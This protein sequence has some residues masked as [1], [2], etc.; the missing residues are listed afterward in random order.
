MFIL[1]V[2]IPD[3]VSCEESQSHC[4]PH[5]QMALEPHAFWFPNLAVDKL[6]SLGACSSEGWD[7]VQSVCV[8]YHKPRHRVRQTEGCINVL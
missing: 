2:Q 4:H 6:A 1:L 8:L 3:S 5:R 7:Q